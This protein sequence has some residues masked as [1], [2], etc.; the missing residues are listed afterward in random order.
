MTPDIFKYLMTGAYALLVYGL[1]LFL[2]NDDLGINTPYQRV[3]RLSIRG[4]L[5]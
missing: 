4:L 3:W 5:Q 2:L 1:T